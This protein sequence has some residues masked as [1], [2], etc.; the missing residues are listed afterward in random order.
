MGDGA[1]NE[2]RGVRYE[3]VG[4]LG[5]VTLARPEASNA[6]DLPAARSLG[7]A[8]DQAESDA[9]RSAI[10]AVLL[11]GEGPRFCAGG[12]VRSFVAADDQPG[13]LR[14]LATALEA[15]L[16]R[17]SE[18]PLPVVAAVQGSVA[19]AGLAFLLN[20]DIVVSARSTRF[21][22]AYA[23]IGLTPDC[24]VSYLLPRAI[25]QQRA[26]ALAL[27]GRVLAADE[28]ADWGLVTE[29]VDDEGLADRAVALAEA[30]AAGAAGPPGALGQAKRL[31]RTAWE[32]SRGDSAVDEVET[33]AAA[34]A[35]PE[36]QERIERFVNR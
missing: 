34:V 3:R 19:G 36:A 14:E 22:M 33:I 31:I 13:Y 18:L 17:L 10:G 20:S 26:L 8:L 7:A 35:S 25:G 27:T 2:P 30:V 9:R 5:R 15:E 29:V 23:G 16:R 4:R 11:T 21:T 6:F 12:D 1:P 32:G 24:G 28:A